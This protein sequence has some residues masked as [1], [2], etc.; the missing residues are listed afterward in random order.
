MLRNTRR[1]LIALLAG[2]ALLSSV[3]AVWAGGIAGTVRDAATLAPLGNIDL[4]L[5]DSSFTAVTIVGDN[6]ASDGTY[7]LSPVP[8]GDY[9]LRADP[10]TTQGYVDQYHPGVFLK[11]QAT[12]LHVNDV[13]TVIVDFNLS[14]GATISGHISDIATGLP[15]E[16]VDLDVYAWDKSYISSVNA[17]TDATGNYAIGCFPPGNFYVRANPAPA[18]LYVNQFYNGKLSLSLADPV[19]VSGTGNFPNINFALSRAGT[20]TGFVSSSPGSLPLAAIDMDLFDAAGVFVSYTDATTAAD[21]SYLFDPI[22]PGDYYVQA[23]P[24]AAQGYIDQYYPGVLD[25][26]LA[27]LVHVTAGLVTGGIDIALPLGGMISGRVTSAVTGLPIAGLRVS[28]FDALGNLV[29]GY[30]VNSAVDGTYLA[31]AMPSGTYFMRCGGD[32]LNGL[33]YEFYSNV[34][35]LSLAFPVLASTGVTVP[36]IDFALDPGGW[37][38]GIVRID[39][40]GLPLGNVPLKTYAY[41]AEFVGALSTKTR[42]D[43]SYR[44]GPVPASSYAVKA[45]PTLLGSYLSQY[46]NHVYAFRDAVLLFIHP[47]ATTSAINFDVRYISPSDVSPVGAAARRPIGVAPNPVRSAS[48]ISFDLDS[49]RRVRLSVFDVSGRMEAVLLDEILPQGRHAIRW[50]GVD[51]AGRPVPNGLHLVRLETATGITEQKALVIR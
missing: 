15:L 35:L 44:I 42:P 24:S 1:P 45:D 2:I 40:G 48:M 4:D 29:S 18:D 30:G 6:T 20:I 27:T 32:S 8:A 22:L 23:D 3:P 37:I 43:G 16:L 39:P 33:A 38:E 9:Y 34:K 31:G 47:G 50:D 13:G 49:A 17:A 11:S 28:V 5:F 36:G 10:S 25:P 46:W 51:D 41:N 7:L 19:A 26:L 12:L 21:G 14:G